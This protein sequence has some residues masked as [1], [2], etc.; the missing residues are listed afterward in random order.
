MNSTDNHKDQKVKKTGPLGLDRNFLAVLSFIIRLPL[1]IVGALLSAVLAMISF[2]QNSETETARGHGAKPV[3]D[4]EAKIFGSY[5]SV[6][7]VSAVAL[8]A[9]RRE[10][11]QTFPSAQIVKAKSWSAEGE[12]VVELSLFGSLA[13]NRI[14]ALVSALE[15]SSRHIKCSL[16]CIREIELL[17]DLG[18]VLN[19]QGMPQRPVWGFTPDQSKTLV[20]LD[21]LVDDK[22]ALEVFCN[23]LLEDSKNYAAIAFR[24]RDAGWTFGDAL[25]Q[26]LKASPD[27]RP[28]DSG[29]GCGYF[30]GRRIIDRDVSLWDG[31][32]LGVPAKE[33]IILEEHTE[34][35]DQ[36][37][38]DLV[39]QI[40]KEK[41]PL[42]L[43][44]QESILQLVHDLVREKM[45]RSSAEALR[46]V[47]DTGR[48]APDEEISLSFFI[49]HEVGLA[50]HQALLAGY[51]LERLKRDME[52][53]LDGAISIDRNW[54]PGEMHTWVRYTY[55]AED[56]YIIDP[57]KGFCGRLDNFSSLRWPYDRPEDL[58][59]PRRAR[60]IY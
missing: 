54:L 30:R 33:A 15:R 14:S 45:P 37:F 58:A 11:R 23:E 12:K 29:G 7:W 53:Y 49:R 21:A 17:P 13:G 36:T 40:R 59:L 4:R 60:P 22:Q 10:H 19:D 16:S 42:G 8:P 39:A 24:G 44:L 25:Q 5:G 56:V 2:F 1:R 38:T 55:S 46:E 31:V 20:L 48:I 57:L 26:R 18:A 35:L 43:A 6:R 9:M 52:H 51:L 32:M 28:P 34:L 47:R 3:V 50:E 41:R 27:F